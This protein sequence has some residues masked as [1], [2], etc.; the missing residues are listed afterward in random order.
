[1]HRAEHVPPPTERATLGSVAS[2]ESVAER[3]ELVAIQVALARGYLQ[4]QDL[5]E[6]VS[7]HQRLQLESNSGERRGLLS[8]LGDGYLR[9]EHLPE[10]R[11]VYEQALKAAG[12][13]RHNSRT[14][15]DRPSDHGVVHDAPTRG[16][17]RASS[18]GSHTALPGCIG[19]Y[20]LMG[21]LGRGGMGVVYRAHDPAL[22]RDVALK[23]LAADATA[24][25]E[26]ERFNREARAAGQLRHP[27][28]VRVLDVVADH[29]PPYIVMDLVEGESL[30]ARIAREGPLEPRAAATLV[31]KIV[32]ALASAH[33]VGLVH[34][35]VKPGN[36]L[37]DAAGEP[38]LTDFGLARRVDE[39][40][41]TRSGDVVGTPH[42]MSPEQA[43]G[44]KDIDGRTDL[45]SV[46]AVLYQLLVGQPPLKEVSL[47]EHMKA[48]LNRDPE[49]PSRARADVPPEMDAIVM[50]CLVR[51]LGARYT[52]ARQLAADL[53]AF[54]EKGGQGTP[55]RSG[56][57]TSLAPTLAVLLLCAGAAATL[58]ILLL[59]SPS[60]PSPPPRPP[61][62]RPPAQM[63]PAPVPVDPAPPA[64]SDQAPALRE[65]AKRLR[66]RGSLE[67][68]LTRIG[69]ALA[70]APTDKD[71]LL[72]RAELHRARGDHR[73]ALADL[74]VVVGLDPTAV[75]PRLARADVHLELVDP[76]QAA[77]DLA[78]ARAGVKG[79]PQEAEVK[80]RLV[81]ALT[82]AG[83]KARDPS[84][85]L[86]FFRD[87]LA[88]DP[89][90]SLALSML[91]QCHL[92]REEFEAVIEVADRALRQAER[93]RSVPNEPGLCLWARAQAHVQL[94]KRE[95]AL[96]DFDRAIEE[97][98]SD[99]HYQGIALYQRGQDHLALGHHTQAQQDAEQAL[100][101]M[102]LD[103]PYRKHAV[104]LLE[105]CRTALERPR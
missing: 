66:D 55:A 73:S 34:R 87:A 33:D 61:P 105:L 36:I 14:Q 78:A 63:D 15:A 11:A 97:L 47:I 23:V 81:S 9:P 41:L 10:L 6:A 93:L 99:A 80:A 25:E 21:E 20:E 45:W 91:V 49:P 56:S 95:A 38:Y 37:M 100:Q 69:E 67:E 79:G 50:R 75:A 17:R 8:V 60:D 70:V 19:R 7:M 76:A 90:H 96:H 77:E 3:A 29:D 101:V 86:A 54:L 83:N 85:S 65:Q 104:R 2:G 22:G 28:V 102:A 64:G 31:R 71:C 12:S 39:A 18:S 62:P 94:G 27:H 72:L 82:A 42:Y 32:G 26:K 51:D 40:R 74:N 59:R 57:G 30:K 52:D 68:A 88:L 44:D 1:M 84:Q 53:D 103:H 98:A 16:P 43:R 4:Q 35:D 46:G 13:D 92:S 89:D 48:L 24:A 58:G 5:R